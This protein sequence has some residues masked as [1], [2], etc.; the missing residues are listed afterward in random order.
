MKAH[1]SVSLLALLILATDARPATITKVLTFER[2][3]FA[4]SSGEVLI[5]IEGCRT[6]A[7]PGAPMVPVYPAVF[8]LPPGEEIVSVTVTPTR[9]E[10]LS[11]PAPA[12]PMPDQVA[13]GQRWA[14]IE[15]RDPS[16]YGSPDFWP[17]SPGELMTVQSKAGVRLAFINVYPLRPSGSENRALFTPEV[18]VTIETRSGLTTDRRIPAHRSVR[19]AASL[20]ADVENPDGLSV[21]GLDGDAVPDNYLSASPVPYVII[22]SEELAGP[23][24][25][26]AS[27]REHHGLRV[28]IVTTAWIDANYPGADIQ[29]RIRQFIRYAWEEWQ[30]EYILLGGDVSV[31]PHRGMYVKAGTEVETDIPSDLYYS[32]LDGDWNSDGDIYFGEPG[33]EDLLP[34]VSIGRLPVESAAQIEAFVNKLI[35]YTESP[36]AGMST[37]AL[38]AGEL[39]WTIDGVDTWGGDCKDEII[40]GSGDYGFTSAGIPAGFSVTTVYDRDIG[41]WGLGELIPI[42]NGGVNLV[43]HLGH[44]NLHSVMRLPIYDLWRLDNVSSGGMPFVCYSQGCYPASFDN[45]DDAGAY[46]AEDCVGEQLVTGTEGAVA[47]IGNT[48]LGWSAPG[49]T[50]GVS[51]FFDRQFFDALFGEG[52]TA[53]GRALDDSRTDNIPFL[54]YAAVRYVMY[55]MCLLGDPAMDIWTKE[56]CALLVDHGDSLE[57]G[58][59]FIEVAVSCGDGPVEGARVSLMSADRGI[60]YTELTGTDGV[61][62]L[63]VETAGAAELELVASAP[64]HFTYNALLFVVEPA[65]ALIEI[66]WLAIDDSGEYGSGDG[67]GLIE[68]G[69][70]VKI[71]LIVTNNGDM[72][73]KNNV[74]KLIAHDDY[75]SPVVNYHSIGDMPPKTSAILP[76][77]FTVDVGESAPDGHIASFDIEIESDLDKRISRHTVAL[78]A[79]GLVLDSF[80]LSD[81]KDGNGNGCI[82][83]WEHL[84][85][86]AGW[87]NNGSVDIMGPVVTI[88]CPAG[89]WARVVK[90]QA[91]LDDIPIGSSIV[92][93]S[94]LEVLIRESAPPFSPIEITL[95]FSADNIA[96]RTETLDVMTCGYELADPDGDISSCSHAPVTG[97]DGWRLSGDDYVSP[98]YSWKC[99]GKDSDVYAN[100]T[101]S[102]LV[103]PPLCLGANTT[104]SFWHR[105]EAEASTAYPYWARDG[106]VVEISTDFGETWQTITPSGNYP[107]RAASTNTIFLAPYE[108][109]FSGTI[110]WKQEIFDLSAW[111]GPAM[112]RFHF[113]SDEQ[114]GF[115]GW[116]IDD[117]SVTTDRV[118]G[119]EDPESG[120]PEATKLLSP[121]PNPFNPA[122]RIPFELSAGGH[123]ELSI[124]DV[125]GRLV[126]T[127]YATRFEAGAHSAAWDGRDDSGRQ[128]S[129]GVYFCRLKTGIYTA[130]SRLVLLR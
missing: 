117:I 104:L 36:P 63:F 18:T 21:Y 65:G 43:N 51:Q 106:A 108:R 76:A 46:Y 109:C 10:I 26:L 1:F 74:I 22:T 25:Q 29:E 96:P 90:A 105:M 77:A 110:G 103:T 5:S 78:N 39:L 119:T 80:S 121:W 53:A 15:G 2:P 20:S 114:Y 4:V 127:L 12:V 89:G 101:E 82:E 97:Y 19:A 67:D 40:T 8:A 54:S 14:G 9:T 64:G 49:S 35:I 102:Y 45:R 17:P 58:E 55:E 94:E 115:E 92:L 41:R 123:V 66:G 3:G 84:I 42:L 23:F 116:Y 44:T 48:R 122:T 129:S 111:S 95:T 13:L 47:F 59:N 62:R 124:Y 86:E 61:A 125:S 24:E 83:A 50:C 34:E 126:R 57:S 7:R 112:I 32:C 52:I 107:C 118:T 130:T 56:P 120:I 16:I 75:L 27:F 81:S 113:A 93:P 6:I 33:E 91:R 72:T 60:Y 73:S 71:D 30:T 68:S 31:I 85:V 38:M 88:S 99:G 79:P 11:M 70:T 87:T 128:V 98:P 69:E 100:M 28:E 37:T